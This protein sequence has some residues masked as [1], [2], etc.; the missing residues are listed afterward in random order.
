MPHPL[1]HDTDIYTLH[2]SKKK[3]TKIRASWARALGL[4]NHG[5]FAG[6]LFYLGGYCIDCQH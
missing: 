1:K 2:Q 5:L 6:D 4:I 3:K